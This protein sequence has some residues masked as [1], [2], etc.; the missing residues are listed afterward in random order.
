VQFNEF[1]MFSPILE[2]CT[3]VIRKQKFPQK[4]ETTF[5]EAG[6]GI[7]RRRRKNIGMGVVYGNIG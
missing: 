4:T 6:Y 5:L 2:W 1:A 3:C 7:F